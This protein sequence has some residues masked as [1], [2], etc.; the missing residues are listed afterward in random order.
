MSSNQKYH[1]IDCILIITIATHTYVY[2]VSRWYSPRCLADQLNF[3]RN[4]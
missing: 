1:K 3:I 2:I 4:L